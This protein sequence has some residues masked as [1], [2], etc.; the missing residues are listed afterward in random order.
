M[1][2]KCELDQQIRLLKEKAAD[3]EAAEE[4]VHALEQKRRDLDMARC[5]AQQVNFSGVCTGKGC[6]S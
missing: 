1:Q 6:R 2:Q 5:L 3:D 4:R